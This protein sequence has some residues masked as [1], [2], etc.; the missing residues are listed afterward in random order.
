MGL[1]LGLGLGPCTARR[2]WRRL[3]RRA[4][5]LSLNM[6]Q[7]LKAESLTAEVSFILVATS[8][9]LFFHASS[10]LSSL[11]VSA[12][13]RARAPLSERSPVRPPGGG[14]GKGLGLG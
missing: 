9:T 13:E 1:K 5:W 7:K 6:V 10:F 3:W 14:W 12:L 2:L 4:F 11:P 8:L